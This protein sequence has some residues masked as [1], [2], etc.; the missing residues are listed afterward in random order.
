MLGDVGPAV[1]SRADPGTLR[2]VVRRGPAGEGWPRGWR[3]TAIGPRGRAAAG[4]APARSSTEADVKPWTLAHLRPA[5]RR[6]GCI[7][8]STPCGSLPSAAPLRAG[9]ARPASS[10]CSPATALAGGL[11][12]LAD[13]P[14]RTSCRWWARRP[15]FPACMAAAIRFVFQPG[16]PARGVPPAMTMCAYRL[17]RFRS[18]AS[19]VGPAVVSSSSSGSVLNLLSGWPAAGLGTE[20]SDHRLA[21]P[22]RRLPGRPSACFPCSTGIAGLRAATAVA[23]ARAGWRT[24]RQ[25]APSRRP[26]ASPLCAPSRRAL[27]PADQHPG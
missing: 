27:D 14:S 18:G 25:R 12:H 2:P 13:S 26:C 20:A 19:A 17:Q 1:G 15:P 4:A 7:S 5:A 8:S 23:D 22:Y 11:A 6:A 3:S 10:A 21:G 24:L 9:S 16:A